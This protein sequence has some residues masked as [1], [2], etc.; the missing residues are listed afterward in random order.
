MCIAPG[1]F[2]LWQ[3]TFLNEG[4]GFYVFIYGKGCLVYY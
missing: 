3:K 4:A 2:N 1:L